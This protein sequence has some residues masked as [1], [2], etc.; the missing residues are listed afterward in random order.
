MSFFLILLILG[1]INSYCAKIRG[2]DPI[3]WFFIGMLFGILGIIAIFLLP[4][5]KPSGEA[6]LQPKTVE[7]DPTPP[8]Y[9]HKDWFFLDEN[10]VQ[11]GPF[12][13]DAFYTAWRENRFTK[14]SYVW[15]EGMAEWKRVEE[16][17]NLQAELDTI[18]TPDHY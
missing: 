10:H 8:K 1:G 15:S 13:W 14:S 17:T 16:I 7:L 9:T 12:S 4:K 5:L 11:Q 6:D 2:R 3:A 18:N